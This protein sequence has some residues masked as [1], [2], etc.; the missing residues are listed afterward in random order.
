MGTVGKLTRLAWLLVNHGEA[1]EADLLPLGV[2]LLDLYRSDAA[3]SLRRVLVLVDGLLMR[4]GTALAASV[5]G[6]RGTWT[7]LEELVASAIGV[8]PPED[9]A[10]QEWKRAN[11]ERIKRIREARASAGA[12]DLPRAIPS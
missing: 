2:D 6:E 12:A 8:T 7:R 3:L 4:R 9:K 1:I 11:Q 10:R 5:A